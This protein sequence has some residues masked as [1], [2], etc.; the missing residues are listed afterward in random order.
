MSPT[1]PAVN[2]QPAVGPVGG[3][4]GSVQV[5]PRTNTTYTL[6]ATNAAGLRTRQV[7]MLVDQGW[8]IA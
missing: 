6:I 2:I 8:P 7:T 5:S 4:T 1:P 3:P